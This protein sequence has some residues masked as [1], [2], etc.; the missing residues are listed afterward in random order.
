MGKKNKKK[1]DQ[2]KQNN[3][4]KFKISEDLSPVGEVLTTTF[5]EI[6]SRSLGTS[7]SGVP[8]NFYDLDAMTQGLQR[9][10]LTVLA[11]RPAMGKTSFSLNMV[12][13]VAKIHDL[14]V[15]LFG[16]EMSKEC[17]TYRLLS[18]N[19]GIEAG[20]LR[21]GRLAKEEWPEL[22]QSIEELGQL[23][24][25]ICDKPNITV[26]EMLAKCEKIKKRQ[27]KELG[28]VVVDYAQMMEGH[29][30]QSRDEELSKVVIALKDMARKLK[31]PVVVLSQL[32]RDLELRDNKRPMLCD[33]RETQ[34]LETH[35]DLVVMLYRDEYYNA[36]T[37]AKGIAELITCKHRN[38][39]VGTVKLLFEPEFTRYRNLAA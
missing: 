15:C 32:N 12:M 26:K 2:S 18:M 35:A 3:Q 24:I 6:E 9:S 21:T 37:E 13:N 19:V 17:Y 39:P 22:D 30:C 7:I 11:G 23:P 27:N 20:R 16:L 4:G 29:A 14:P 36:E 8:V 10:S 25:F 28:L 5:D 1:K 34:A 31:V 33:L 38:G